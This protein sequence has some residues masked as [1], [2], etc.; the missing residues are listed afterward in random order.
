MRNFEKKSNQNDKMRIWMISQRFQHFA[1][2]GCNADLSKSFRNR[3]KN[4]K[5]I[6]A[7]VDE[8]RCRLII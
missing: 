4:K 8:A 5:I 1:D 3:P 7:H 6:F 2:E